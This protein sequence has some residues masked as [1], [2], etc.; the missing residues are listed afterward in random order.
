MRREELLLVD[1]VE[2]TDLIAEV[3]R[4]NDRS[5]LL[6]DRVIQSALLMMLLMIGEASRRLPDGF[7][8]RHGEVPWTDIIR[9]LNLALH[10]YE[11][12]DF[13]EVWRIAAEDVPPV[14]EAVLGIL[15]TEYPL[16]AEALEQHN[17][18]ER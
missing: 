17:G 10:T 7:R 11:R 6:E 13:A 1:I 15:Q 4:D 14:R 3:L 5:D 2:Q 12:L 9:F 8:E 18:E 16:V